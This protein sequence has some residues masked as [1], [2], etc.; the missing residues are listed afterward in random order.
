MIALWFQYSVGPSIVTETGWVW[1]TYRA[2]PGTGNLVYKAWKDE[3]CT[4]YSGKLMSQCAGNAGV[5]RPMFLTTSFFSI[6]AL[7]VHANPSLNREAW[8]AKY[9]VMFFALIATMFIPNSPLFSGFYLWVARLAA[10]AFVVLQQIILIDVSY[11][12]NDDWVERSN[13]LDRISYGEGV[14]WL[15][16]IMGT[17]VFLYASALTGIGLLYHYFDGCAENTWVITLTLLGMIAMTAIQ[18][19][20]TEG[21]V[22]TSAIMSAYSVYLTFSIVSKNPN[23]TCNP[24]LGHHDV[25]GIIVGLVLTVISLA[26]T[27]WSWTAEHR[28]NLDG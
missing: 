22:L 1:R 15:R 11:N 12:L 7:V 10:A 9:T 5:F 25:W 8:P 6:S 4:K 3:S 18:L 24:R 27:G 14:G 2:L 13:E 20:G 26:W 28:L 21:S 23:G 16:L 19:S 17:S